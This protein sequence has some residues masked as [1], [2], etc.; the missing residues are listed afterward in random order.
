MDIHINNFGFNKLLGLV[1]YIQAFT[2]QVSK[3]RAWFDVCLANHLH[4]LWSA[5]MENKST[6]WCAYA[7]SSV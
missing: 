6:E 1:W 7:V 2:K 3:Y 4:A 5:A